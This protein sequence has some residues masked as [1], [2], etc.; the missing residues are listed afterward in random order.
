MFNFLYLFTDADLIG[1]LDIIYKA[2]SYKPVPYTPLPLPRTP[3]V[4]TWGVSVA[5]KRKHDASR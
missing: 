2:K 1:S 5:L 3:S 4:E